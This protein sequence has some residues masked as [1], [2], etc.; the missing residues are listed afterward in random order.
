MPGK[1]GDVSKFTKCSEFLSLIVAC[2]KLYLPPALSQY[3]AGLSSHT[4]LKLTFIDYQD[5]PLSSSSSSCPSCLR[6]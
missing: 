6:I 3:E 5:S 2:E 4:S 1:C